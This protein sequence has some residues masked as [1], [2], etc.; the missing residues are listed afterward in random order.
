[1]SSD[2]PPP[3][4]LQVG[5]P[6]VLD[7]TQVVASDLDEA[8]GVIYPFP[9]EFWLIHWNTVPI[10]FD[11]RYDL[12]DHVESL[13]SILSRV[14]ATSSGVVRDTL[15]S[16]DLFIEWVI[17]W[18]G[19]DLQWAAKWVRVRG[20][21]DSLNRRCSTCTTSRSS[22]LAEWLMLLETLHKAVEA[23]RITLE[24]K[25][26]FVE[27]LEVSGRLRQLGNSAYLYRES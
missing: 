17:S 3:C 6:R 10:P 26:L 1:M 12:A 21:V 23:S 22:F 19:D 11:Y 2:N 4:F 7:C 15:A 24:D 14:A 9:T 18:D 20:D 5:S 25:T 8:I 16:N 13:L 27:L